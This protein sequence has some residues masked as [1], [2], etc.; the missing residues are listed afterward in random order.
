MDGVLERE[1]SEARKRDDERLRKHRTA[2][3]TSAT[4]RDQGSWGEPVVPGT[5]TVLSG[6]PKK[7]KKGKKKVADIAES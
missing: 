6:K 3:V 5:A 1:L 4:Q 7:K 2:Q